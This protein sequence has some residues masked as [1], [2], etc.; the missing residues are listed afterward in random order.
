MIQIEVLGGLRVL[1]NGETQ[2]GWVGRRQRAAALVYLAVEG[3]T[4]REKLCFLLWPDREQHK[5][6]GALNQTLYELRRDLGEDW[7]QVDGERLITTGLSTDLTAL[8]QSTR[9]A[10]SPPPSGIRL[11]PFLDGVH[12]GTSVEFEHWVDGKRSE[13]HG[14]IRK[15]F[16]KIAAS[17]EGDPSARVE[18]MRA[19]VALDP[20]EDEAQHALIRCLAEAGLRKEALEQFDRYEELLRSELDLRPLDDTL[21]LMRQIRQGEFEPVGFASQQIAP[22]ERK[23]SD[24]IAL[25]PQLEVARLI[26][27]GTTGT[28]YLAREPLLRRL[29]AVKVLDSELASHPTARARF[30]REAQSAARIHHPNVVSVYRVGATPDGT[31]YIVMP[32]VKGTTLADRI[33][34]DGNVSS[35]E[36]VRILRCLAEAL[37]AAHGQD[38]VHRDVRPQNVLVEEGTGRVLLTD[39][40]I[41]ATLESGDVEI[42]RLTRTGELLGNPAYVS[43]EQR[44]GDA[45]D[46]RSDVYSLGVLGSELLAGRPDPT[47]ERVNLTEAGPE[48]A[49]LLKRARTDNPKRRPSAAQIARELT[50]LLDGS[51]GS[52]LERLRTRRFLPIIGTYLAAGIAAMGGVDQL[53]QQSLLPRGAYLFSLITFLAGLNGAAVVAWFHGEKGRQPTTKQEAFLLLVVVI[54]WGI[55]LAVALG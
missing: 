2:G 16:R 3:E 30:E 19:W 54:A 24:L 50:D 21:E 22:I 31:P 52:L 44:R 32:Y 42:A 49:A 12:L 13:V 27:T 35:E 33:A 39:F 40:G 29:V 53:V 38:V 8:R 10:Q 20:L 41:A 45:V 17:T 48:L 7:L 46:D 51:G 9:D 26:G 47:G 43:P 6:R 36:A 1:A 11:E 14:L 18:S 37:S 23:R 25:D 15:T 55:A 34:S 28:V 5:A 4:T